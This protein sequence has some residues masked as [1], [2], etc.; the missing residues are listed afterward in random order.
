M[1][2]QVVLILMLYPNKLNEIALFNLTL[3]SVTIVEWD[4]CFG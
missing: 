1:Q 3:C 2:K 4:F